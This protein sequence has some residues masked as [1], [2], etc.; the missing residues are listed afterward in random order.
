MNDRDMTNDIS[1]VI[2]VIGSRRLRRVGCLFLGAALTW[3]GSLPLLAFP[4]SATTTGNSCSVCHGPS[5]GQ[6]RTVPGLLAISGTSLL[7]DLGTQLDG[8][9]R[10]PLKTFEALPGTT[11][12]LSVDVLPAADLSGPARYS[13][14][15]KRLEKS[16]QQLSTNNF[17]G[18]TDAN[19]AGSGWTKRDNP[20][21]PEG[22]TDPYYTK[23]LEVNQ[24]GTFTFKLGLNPETP[25]DVYDLEFAIAGVDEAGL[26]Y[27]DRH[28]YLAVIAPKLLT[29]G[30]VT[31]S[32][33]LSAAGYVLQVADS[34][35]GPW[36]NYTGGTAVI[37]GT[38]VALMHVA[39][40]SKKFWR[41]YKP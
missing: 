4:N 38:N 18:W 9:V 24:T 29:D 10:G 15:L 34:P 30:A 14:Q 21:V 25:V 16:G 1:Q 33:A 41:L 5:P 32:E 19:A 13:L 11:V 26:L 3:L 20:N 22:V 7:T 31:W 40:G 12:T 35:E 6:G 39:S 27:Y 8:R 17:L 28:F 37:D 36:Q 23:D 2:K